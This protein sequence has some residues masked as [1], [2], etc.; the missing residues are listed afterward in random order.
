MIPTPDP[1]RQ[2]RPPD[3]GHE[4]RRTVLSLLRDPDF[5]RADLTDDERLIYTVGGLVCDDAGHLT[6]ADLTAAMTDLS[7]VQYARN[8]LRKAGGT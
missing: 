6:Q 8:L 1:A 5:R 7:V 4:R 3:F 2:P